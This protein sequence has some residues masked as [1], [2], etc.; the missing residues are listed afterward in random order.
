MAEGKV[1]LKAGDH[2]PVMPSLEVVGKV[3]EPPTQVGG[4]VKVGVT[5][6]ITVMVMVVVVKQGI[7]GMGGLGLKV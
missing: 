4:I 5:F 7:P 2:A 6:G 1:L 3:S